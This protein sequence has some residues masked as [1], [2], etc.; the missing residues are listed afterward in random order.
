MEVRKRRAHGGKKFRALDRD[1]GRSVGNTESY[2]CAQIFTVHNLA[3]AQGLKQ[4][5]HWSQTDMGSD[6]DFTTYWLWD[7]GQV[8]TLLGFRFSTYKLILP[9]SQGNCENSI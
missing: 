8:S 1:P 5:G 3:R 9:T 6:P 7:L 4:H 2:F